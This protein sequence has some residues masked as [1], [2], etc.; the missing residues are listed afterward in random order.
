MPLLNQL[1]PEDR[2]TRYRRGHG[3]GPS[4]LA[5]S[6]EEL[7]SA[8]GK[9][10]TQLGHMCDLLQFSQVLEIGRTVLSLSQI[11]RKLKFKEIKFYLQRNNC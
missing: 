1:G 9:A 8:L 5:A 10:P 7:V 6:E 11:S 2:V 3:Y 4:I